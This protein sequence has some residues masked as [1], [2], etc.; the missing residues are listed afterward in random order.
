MMT[1]S[2]YQVGVRFSECLFKTNNCITV[3]TACQR[4]LLIFEMCNKM[5]TKQAL[6]KSQTQKTVG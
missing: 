4:N 2:T 3:W 5:S 1:E 6:C